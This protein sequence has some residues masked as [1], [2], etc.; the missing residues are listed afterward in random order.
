MWERLCVRG[1]EWLLKRNKTKL[2]SDPSKQ[3]HIHTPASTVLQ[4]VSR[5][6]QR[7]ECYQPLFSLSISLGGDP[8]E[9]PRPL[10]HSQVLLCFC[11]PASPVAVRS[12]ALRAVS[13]S[14]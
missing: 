3:N 2:L 12:C 7:C 13:F 14:I 4:D 8:W 5:H 9:P 1:M 6:S 11:V 10:T